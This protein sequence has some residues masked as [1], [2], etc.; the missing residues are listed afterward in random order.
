MLDRYIYD[1]TD[2]VIDVQLDYRN[3]HLL[4]SIE[5][6]EF[7]Y[8]KPQSI[9]GAYK[10]SISL[11]LPDGEAVTV[12]KR[13]SELE[14]FCTALMN[15]FPFVILPSFPPKDLS[16]KYKKDEEKV[17]ARGQALQ[18]FF[19]K[20]ITNT[21]LLNTN[22]LTVLQQHKAESK[23][24]STALIESANN[25]IELLGNHGYGITSSMREWTAWFEHYN[26]LSTYDKICENFIHFL[27]TEHTIKSQL[28]MF[29]ASN[30]TSEIF[31]SN[32]RG[33]KLQLD[34]LVE[35]NHLK[36]QVQE[37]QDVLKMLHL[38]L[39]DIRSYKDCLKRYFLR[40]KRKYYDDSSSFASMFKDDNVFSSLEKSQAL[41]NSA[42]REIA[43]IK[44][45]LDMILPGIEEDLKYLLSR[46][47]KAFE[48][49]V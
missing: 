34:P 5:N 2:M 43:L 8:E 15:K 21:V 41:P 6:D 7:S 36:L 9:L 31:R 42:K 23:S 45:Q 13:Y 28:I 29:E 38:L 18:M 3:Q 48:L 46:T 14:S 49:N 22:F 10:Y 40:I 26:K 12:Y 33:D 37:H 24:P 11:E 17:R 1:S 4:K 47:N 35:R 30:E 16:M 44:K 19:T 25:F 39:N 20:L 27:D 32:A